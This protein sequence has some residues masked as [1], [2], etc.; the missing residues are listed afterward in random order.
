MQC[1]GV[2]LCSYC[3]S[4]SVTF[5]FPRLLGEFFFPFFFSPKSKMILHNSNN[6][7]VPVRCIQIT[8][9]SWGEINISSLPCCL[10]T[11]CRA[12]YQVR[13]C[14]FINFITATRLLLDVIIQ[15]TAPVFVCTAPAAAHRLSRQGDIWC[16]TF[17]PGAPTLGTADTCAADPL[18]APH[19]FRR[20][21]TSQ[22]CSFNREHSTPL[23]GK[24]N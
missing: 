10:S 16:C 3:N 23:R 24:D 22:S 1:H 5:P 2:T 9:C 14:N 4:N 21:V 17:A 7:N 18:G 13:T 6:V 12:W 20:A 19:P 8:G 11:R 15:H